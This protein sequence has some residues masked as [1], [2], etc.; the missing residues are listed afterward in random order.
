M[1]EKRCARRG[2]N[3]WDSGVGFV[4]KRARNP[5]GKSSFYYGGGGA[6]CLQRSGAARERALGSPGAF[7]HGLVWQ[8]SGRVTMA[9]VEKVGVR[10][11]DSPTSTKHSSM[12]RPS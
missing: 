2:G 10:P 9:A 5:K 7:H 6:G 1:L 11:R 12:S 8:P 3:K 4:G